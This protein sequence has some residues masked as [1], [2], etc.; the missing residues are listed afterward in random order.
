MWT[1]VE[2]SLA[3]YVTRFGYIII[4]MRAATFKKKANVF[5]AA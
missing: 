2:N 4:I 1:Q 5:Q 3:K